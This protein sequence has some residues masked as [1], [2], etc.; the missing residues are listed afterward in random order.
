MQ[1]GGV[2]IYFIHPDHLDTPRAVVNANDQPIWL[3]DSAPFGDTAANEQP[4]AG[5]PSFTF[6]LRFP[7]QQYDRETG[8]HYNYFRDYEA[9]TG[10]YVQSDPIGLRGGSNAFGYL[11]GD[12]VNSFDAFGLKK[13]IKSGQDG[14]GREDKAYEEICA[15]YPNDNVQRECYLRNDEGK[16]AVDGESGE[17]RRIDFIV[18]R[19]QTGDPIKSIEVTSLTA[20]KDVQNAKEERIRNDGGNKARNRRTKCVPSKLV[21]PTELWRRK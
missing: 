7:G 14:K 17:A 9:Q 18:F 10:R 15:C 20:D 13:G 8:T 1:A 21:P 6:N 16:I 3:W 12:P 11:S 19:G 5:L 4:T 2:D